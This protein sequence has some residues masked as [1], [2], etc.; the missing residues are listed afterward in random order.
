[1]K[2]DGDVLL[3]WIS[4]I[5]IGLIFAYVLVTHTPYWCGS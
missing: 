1:M 3:F 5:L 4:M 2:V